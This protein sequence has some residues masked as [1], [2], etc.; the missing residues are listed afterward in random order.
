MSIVFCFSS[1]RVDGVEHLSKE[2]TKAFALCQAMVAQIYPNATVKWSGVRFA[3]V[4]QLW[5]LLQIRYWGIN[6]Q[7]LEIHCLSYLSTYETITACEEF[8]KKF[9]KRFL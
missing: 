9:W 6:L 4:T 5:I 8:L 7:L 3:Y 2:P 1:T